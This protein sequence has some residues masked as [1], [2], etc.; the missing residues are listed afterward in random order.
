VFGLCMAG[1]SLVFLMS[2]NIHINA[3]TGSSAHV[4]FFLPEVSWV[5]YAVFTGAVFAA[6]YLLLRRLVAA[7]KK[8]R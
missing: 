4:H 7:W 3:D 2:W 6:F 8:R 5:Y 1:L